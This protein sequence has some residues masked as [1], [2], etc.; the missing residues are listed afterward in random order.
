MDYK[1]LSKKAL[2][3]HLI[4]L[5]AAATKGQG[6]DET[7]RLLHELQ[8]QQIELEVQ[9]R[10]LRESQQAL[11]ESRDRYA[12]LY[13]FAPVGYVILDE[14]GIIKELNLTASK[15][16]G[17]E[18]AELLGS[19]FANRAV[20]GARKQFLTHIRQVFQSGQRGVTEL[21][22]QN[23]DTGSL[24]MRL[25]SVLLRPAKGKSKA[26]HT[27][28]I[29]ITERTR[30]EQA[31]TT[32]VHQQAGVANLGQSALAG[33]DV[34][35]L[36]DQAVI[37][38]A[39]GLQVDFTKVLE[40]VPGGEELFLRAGVGWEEGIV[41]EA[42]VGAGKDSQPGYTLFSNE[43]VVVEDLRQETRFSGPALLDDHGVVSGISIV[44]PGRGK[45]FGVFGIHTI[46]KRIFS[47]EDIN[48]LQAVSN[49]LAAEIERKRA[50]TALQDE[51]DA[52]EVRV[53]E[54]TAELVRINDEL[55]NEV[56]ER[57]RA[58]R[59]LQEL[60][61]TL[62]QRVAN[63]TVE[64]KRRAEELEQFAYVAS[65]DL[66]APLRGVAN[67]A[68][69]LQE[70]LAGT[71]SDSSDELLVLLLDRVQ[72]MQMLIDGLLEYSRVGRMRGAREMVD[73]SEMLAETIDSL[74]LPE[75]VVVDVAPDMPT[76]HTDRLRLGQVFANLI[77]N[78]IKHYRNDQAHVWVGVR[79]SG[80]FY[81]FSVAD[82][83]PGIAP[84]YHQKVF[85]MFQTLDPKD[86]SN[87]SGIGL[88]LVKKI[89]EEYGGS[90]TLESSEDKG[91]TFR[92]TWLKHS[93]LDS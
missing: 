38:A 29:D 22:M 36:C 15:M 5:Q 91:A 71:L 59:K 52:L 60:N 8:I 79:D 62:E 81:E 64:A 37:L 42:M 43:P 83:G 67:L 31:L 14:K 46:E 92:F 57:R 63:R 47:K 25:E 84:Q 17:P 53:K 26:C 2:I 77:D 54:R 50:E 39:E 48:F 80:S 10:E 58:E 13:D 19:P 61:E 88:A 55:E 75:H 68:D 49:I 27:A 93:G 76:L 78:A 40:L 20:K 74:A 12:N 24:H 11:E 4:T 16:L 35:E 23:S 66:K 32:H 1:K 6:G 82:D 89:V 9:N 65:H 45:P 85:M 41:G 56:A 51:H 70:D 3:K 18:R 30:V 87:S 21:K 73:I 90:I 44:I 86:V 7:K 28:M 72:R 69:W 33:I 34:D